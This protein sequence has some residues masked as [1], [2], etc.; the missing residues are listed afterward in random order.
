MDP[1]TYYIEGLLRQSSA[2]YARQYLG[3]QDASGYNL[4]TDFNSSVVYGGYFVNRT[5]LWQDVR[6]PMSSLRAG[7]G[8]PSAQNFIVSGPITI[9]AYQFRNGFTERL[10]FELQ[11]PHGLNESATYGVRLHVHWSCQSITSP[12]TV[13][14]FV[15]AA[16]GDIN[17]VLGG[18]ATYGPATGL[19]TVGYQ[20]IVTP[21]HTFTGL[22]DSGLIVGNIYRDIADS[23]ANNDVFGLSLDA[24]Y[25]VQ[26]AGSLDEMG[27]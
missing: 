14:W 12:N 11:I 23:Y 7:A 19:T 6:I 25:V 5:P 8:A 3:I 16:V 10:E 20:H 21:I 27:D 4:L 17:G 1:T 26:K 13:G 9:R 15:D 22:H 18:A 2:A 24:H